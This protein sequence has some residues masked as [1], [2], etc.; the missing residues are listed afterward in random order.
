[1]LRVLQC[2]KTLGVADVSIH[3]EFFGPRQAMSLEPLQPH[4]TKTKV[5]PHLAAMSQ[6]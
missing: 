6:A 4:A 5:R 2:L 3:Y 1:M